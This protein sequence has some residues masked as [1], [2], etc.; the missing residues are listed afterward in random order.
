MKLLYENTKSCSSEVGCKIDELKKVIVLQQSS[1]TG[2]QVGPNP[3]INGQANPA[4]MENFLDPGVVRKG[5]DEIKEQM[6]DVQKEAH[7]IESD[8]EQRLQNMI[9]ANEAKK[10]GIPASLTQ[11]LEAAAAGEESLAADVSKIPSFNKTRDL[12][13]E[14]LGGPFDYSQYAEDLRQIKVQR[15][16]LVRQFKREQ[17]WAPEL[18]K[19]DFGGKKALYDFS[20]RPL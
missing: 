7:L 9:A 13:T 8:M 19:D 6:R 3:F 10:S 16:Q 20:T 12:I 1:L 18:K 11:E 2:G 15:D 5:M 4:Q 17:L 14:R